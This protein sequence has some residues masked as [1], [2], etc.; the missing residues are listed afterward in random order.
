M[1]LRRKK[2]QKVIEIREQSL[3][4]KAAVLAQ[5]HEGREL[6]EGQV[7]D[8]ANHLSVA[9]EYRNN[10]ASSL[11]NVSSWIDAEQWLANKTDQHV[12]AQINLQSAEVLLACAHEKVIE[13]RSQVKRMKLLDKRLASGELRQQQRSEQK[14]NDEHAQRQNASAHRGYDVSDLER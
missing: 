6:A 8:A 14:S 1:T 9:A 11:I 2:I 4:E 7:L 12:R 13:A 10:L 5:A 3:E